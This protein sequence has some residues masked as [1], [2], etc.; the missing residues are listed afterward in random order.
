MSFL[1]GKKEESKSVEDTLEEFLTYLKEKL[2]IGEEHTRNSQSSK[3]T[4]TCQPSLRFSDF[5]GLRKKVTT[6]SRGNEK[7]K[8]QTHKAN[9]FSDF[10]EDLLPTKD[11]SESKRGSTVQT[12]AEL[13]EYYR[14]KYSL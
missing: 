4:N 8:N 10:L 12:R 6:G 3:E 5:V 13:V 1:A 9:F 11:S 7:K 14:K 2:Y